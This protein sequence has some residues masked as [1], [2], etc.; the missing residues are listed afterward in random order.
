MGSNDELW[1]TSILSPSNFVFKIDN[2][3]GLYFKGNLYAEDVLIKYY[4]YGNLV[5][6]CFKEEKDEY[7][8]YTNEYEYVTVYEDCYSASVFQKVSLREVIPYDAIIIDSDGNEI[9]SGDYIL[10]PCDKDCFN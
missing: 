8:F 2:T 3:Y 9:E 1:E 10:M 6:V 4:G 7:N 5:S